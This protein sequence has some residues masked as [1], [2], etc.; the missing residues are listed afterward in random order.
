MG[1]F[2]LN[3]MKYKQR[4]LDESSVRLNRIYLSRD[5]KVVV[6]LKKIYAQLHDEIFE[7]LADVLAFEESFIGI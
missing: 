3:N 7:P 2:A 4:S 6:S 5:E 1:F